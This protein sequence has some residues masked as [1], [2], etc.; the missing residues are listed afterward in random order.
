ML[1]PVRLLNICFNTLVA[2]NRDFAL[3][4]KIRYIVAISRTQWSF[5]KMGIF[6]ILLNTGD[7]HMHKREK[8]NY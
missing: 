7:S 6:D 1:A 8:M 2:K 5:S 3:L 4:S